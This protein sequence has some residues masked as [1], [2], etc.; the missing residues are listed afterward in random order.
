MDQET[1]QLF[2]D[3]RRWDPDEFARRL[4]TVQTLIDRVSRFQASEP[5]RALELLTVLA[6]KALRLPEADEPARERIL[7]ACSDLIHAQGGRDY[8]IDHEYAELLRRRNAFLKAGTYFE[9]AAVAYA[10]QHGPAFLEARPEGD[11]EDLA[12]TLWREAAACYHAGGEAPQAS[13]CRYQAMTRKRDQARGVERLLQWASCLVW[14]WGER[15]WRVVATGAILIALFAV[16][17]AAAGFIPMS[18]SWAEN[19][20][21]ALYLSVITFTTVGYGHYLPASAAGKLLA[22]LEG[23][24]GIVCTGLFLVTFVKRFAR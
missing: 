23:L 15:P 10:R 20:G 16:G 3:V 4:D 18:D 17:Y 5:L 2:E 22:G 13:R 19:L 11:R 14:G 8:R 7:R 1:E 9:R 6:S 21:N 12:F 24:L